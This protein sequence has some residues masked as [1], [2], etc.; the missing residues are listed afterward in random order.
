M[1]RASICAPSK[2][3]IVKVSY[4]HIKYRSVNL[5]ALL[6]AVVYVFD[7]DKRV[8]LSNT[9]ERPYPDARKAFM[10]LGVKYLDL[11][12]RTISNYINRDHSTGLF[13][14][15]A[16]EDLILTSKGFKENVNTVKRMFFKS[17]IIYR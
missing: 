14:V 6:D 11:P 16:A 8:L 3:Q 2:F 12:K 9:R 4:Q 15:T 17:L 10:F 7:V 5:K 13:C 1:L